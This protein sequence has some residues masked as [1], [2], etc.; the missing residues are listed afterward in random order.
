MTISLRLELAKLEESSATANV[1][2]YITSR[3]NDL[4]QSVEIVRHLH[5]EGFKK[6]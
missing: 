6:E 3:R 1:Q 4:V 5:R 2:V